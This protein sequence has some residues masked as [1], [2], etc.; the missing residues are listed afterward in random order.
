MK[1]LGMFDPASAEPQRVQLTGMQALTCLPLLQ[2]AL[3]AK[4]GLN[5]AGFISGYRGSPLGG[6]DTELA[7]HK[8][9][10]AAAN[11]RFEPGL[12]EDLAATAMI[13]TQQVPLMDDARVDGVFGLWYGKGPGVD[14]SGDPF[15]HGVRLGA[16]KHGGVLLAFGDD[17]A[18]KS[19][20]VAHASEDMLAANGIPVLYPAT[21]A[22]YLTFGTFGWAMSRFSGLWVGMK[23]V[24]ETA[25]GTVSTLLPAS[26]GD[27][28]NVDAEGADELNV[29][30]G[31]DPL[32]DERRHFAL[33]LPA[34]ERFAEANSI[35]RVVADSDRRT[36]GIVTAGKSYLDTCEALRLL[37]LDA[38]AAAQ[39]GLRV[40][41]LGLVHPLVRSTLTGF[42]AGHGELLFVEEKTGLIEAQAANLLFNLPEALRPRVTGKKMLVGEVQFA[43]HGV[44][45][46][47]QIAEVIGR[48][49]ER[50]GEADAGLL[51]SLEDIAT[52]RSESEKRAS[53]LAS[54]KPWFCSGC[55]HSSSTNLPDGS[56]AFTGIGCHTMALWMDR[57]SLPP[58][59]MGGEGA[60]WIGMAPFV[61]R[62][63]IFQNLGDGTYN[64]SGLLAIRA[65]VGAGHPVTYKILYNDA[66]AM[67]GGQPHEGSLTVPD[68]AAQVM[69]E[70]VMRVAIVTDDVGRYQG[71]RLPAGVEVSDR[72]RIMA[73]Q[74]SLREVPGV[75][76]LIYDQ[77]CATELRRRRKRGLLPKPT[78]KVII[79]ELVCEGCGDCSRASNCVSV[80]PSP[81]EWG[82]KRRINQSTC[83]TDM[84]CVEGMCPSFVLVEGATLARPTQKIDASIFAALPEAAPRAL[85]APYNI[86]VA[87]IGGTGIVTINALIGAAAYFEDKSFAAYDMTGLAQKGGAVFSHMRISDSD[88]AGLSPRVGAGEADLVVAAD[89]GIATTGDAFLAVDRERTTLVMDERASPPG[90]FQ[91]DAAIDL[92]TFAERAK[93]ERAVQPDNLFCLNAA[94]SAAALLGDT[95]YG[96]VMLLG[97]TQQLGLLPL[98]SASIERAIKANGTQA[99]N[100]LIAFNLGRLAAHD[101][102]RFEGLL[103][104]RAV[105]ELPEDQ[106]LD[107]L[108]ERRAAM[109]A[110][111]QDETY[112]E[113]FRAHL[114]S[115]RSSEERIAPGSSELT[116]AVA[117]SL[118]RLMAYKDE[119]EV[120]RL[121]TDGAFAAQLRSEFGKVGKLEFVLA[122]PGLALR[123]DARGHPRK[124]RLGPW[125]L[126]AFGVLKRFK[127]L[128]GTIFDP[129]R[130]SHDRRL[131]R[132]LLA[133][134]EALFARL[135]AE[136]DGGRLAL[137]VKIAKLPQSICGYGHVKLAAAERAGK[138]LS[139]LLV[140]W[141]AVPGRA[142]RREGAAAG[143]GAP[144]LE[145][146][147]R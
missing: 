105:R 97:Y 93:L 104:E 118:H 44:L 4:A 117:I 65:A 1:L 145:V 66:V 125:I 67:T 61:E 85:S 101:L 45:E 131:E 30:F 14:R 50:L 37:G 49:L 102:V 82:L 108:I 100:N 79:N 35:D 106:P 132:D 57:D 137:A 7:R 88:D 25:E 59:Q 5:T 39:K 135:A 107:E 113:R 41:K 103:P 76:V 92:S 42:A 68:I 120:A 91:L 20:T 119:Y 34:A 112:A 80:E 78:Q 84:S 94:R 22:E 95:V 74:E 147:D 143:R 83:N 31:F 3:D 15:K 28:E 123:K 121:Y 71:V 38:T 27:F 46:P 33:R 146:S 114:A 122:P 23:C 63:H 110:N 124:I 13:G 47:L 134:Y 16:S 48:A 86:I 40:L 21:I 140:Q 133:T 141:D 89:L 139:A 142:A 69:A 87:G 52:R 126:T 115:V 12:N 77:T 55:P 26:F 19:S 53:G 72:E 17:H 36:L 60:N 99:E 136:L 18:G 138:S 8:K 10:L 58:V 70:R 81:T 51:A 127:G 56:V 24:N 75:S 130:W 98:A 6:F 43:A 109:L 2:R 116:R 11:I 29:R 128:R 73:V 62:P 54:R 129:F 9:E 64:H 96:N 90:Q 32:G 111:Y 144:A